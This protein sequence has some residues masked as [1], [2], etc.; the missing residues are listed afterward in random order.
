M[1]PGNLDI[2]TM[3]TPYTY[4]HEQFGYSVESIYRRLMT[5]SDAS[6]GI[7]PDTFP[8]NIAEHF[9]IQEGQGTVR[10]W[11]SIGKLTTGLYFYFT[12]FTNDKDG[13]FYV[14]TVTEEV[15]VKASV[16]APFVPIEFKSPLQP[17]DNIYTQLAAASILKK[18]HLQIP[19]M[20]TPQLQIPFNTANI[21]STITITKAIKPIVTGH[22][23]LW[24]STRYSDLIQYAMD[25]ETYEK[26][27][28]EAAVLQNE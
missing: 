4:I 16:E 1:A 5:Q 22:M 10:P 13:K 6:L 11:I 20:S 2:N 25:S 19:Q 15:P 8:N 14:T 24:L 26:Y 21:M 27:I 3:Q 28:V 9:W 23:N 12:A 7:Y 17:P 18:P